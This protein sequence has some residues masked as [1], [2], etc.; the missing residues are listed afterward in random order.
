[1]NLSP[2]FVGEGVGMGV[3]VGDDDN[4]ASKVMLGP[5]DERRRRG[6]EHL[7]LKPAQAFLG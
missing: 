1:M 6:L 4:T 5:E 3:S 2:F 7:L